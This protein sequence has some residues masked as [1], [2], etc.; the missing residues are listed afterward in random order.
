M[1]MGFGCSRLGSASASIGRRAAIRLVH[2]AVDEGVV[3][4]D[5]ADAYGAGA[6]E[7]LL[8][9]ALR[10][11]RADVVIATKG[12]YRFRAR[13]SVEQ[14]ARRSLHAV[15]RLA[16]RAHA[17]QPALAPTASTYRSQD[18]SPA[19]LRRQVEASLRRLRTDHVD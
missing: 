6:S 5:T 12:G 10:G 1:Q 2:E 16:P 3:L 19:V 14:V 18:F 17:Q 4:F 11:R 15:T 7:R 8:G 9:T 13:S